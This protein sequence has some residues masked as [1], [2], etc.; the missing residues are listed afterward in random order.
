MELE[1]WGWNQLRCIIHGI[2]FHSLMVVVVATAVWH[3]PVLYIYCAAWNFCHLQIEDG[4]NKV[5]QT[6]YFL[7]SKCA[8]F[9][10][11]VLKLSA[12][13]CF[14]DRKTTT[15]VGGS[16]IFLQI[17][18]PRQFPR[19][20]KGDMI[21]VPYWRLTRTHAHTHT[22]THIKHHHQKFSSVSDLVTGNFLPLP[23]VHSGTLL[24]L[25]WYLEGKCAQNGSI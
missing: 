4:Y 19:C 25:N 3:C 18:A 13:F 12:V 22:H 8:L 17:Q 15:Q 14:T 16:H 24:A 5:L 11:F 1:A 9:L 10:S 23:K 7:A 6:S 2:S 21:H 20:Q